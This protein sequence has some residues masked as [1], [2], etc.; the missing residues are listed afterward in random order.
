MGGLNDF[1][2]DAGECVT[3]SVVLGERFLTAWEAG[4]V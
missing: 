2:A 3:R 1:N 4:N